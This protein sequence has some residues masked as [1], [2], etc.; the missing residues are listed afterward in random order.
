MWPVKVHEGAGSENPILELLYYRGR[1]QLATHD[2]LYSDG[3]KYRPLNIAFRHIG[4]DLASVKHIMVLGT[5]LGSVVDIVS[6]KGYKP[7]YTL[8][9][10]DKTVLKWALEQHSHLSEYIT[11]VHADA[12]TYIADNKKQYDIV[13]VDV[14][15]S[16]TV[17]EFVTTISF[18]AHCR[19]AVKE[20]GYFVQNYIVEDEK[21]WKAA[22]ATFRSVFPTSICTDDGLNR[23]IIAKV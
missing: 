6:A 5:G 3:D 22:D 7:H 18:L 17:P 20:G 19:E 11:P 21:K 9:E 10:Y 2:A 12:K 1:L 16:R 13:I 8:V 15:N 23:V 14:F 4:N